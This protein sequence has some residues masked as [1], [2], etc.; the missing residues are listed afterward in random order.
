MRDFF[1]RPGRRELV[2]RLLKIRVNGFAGSLSAM[3]A[4]A[5]LLA[6]HFGLRSGSLLHSWFPAFSRAHNELGPGWMRML[7]HELITAAPVNGLARIDLGRGDEDWKCR[8]MT[9]SVS[10]CEGEVSAHVLRRRTQQ[11][12]TPPSIGLAP[13]RSGRGFARPNAGSSGLAPTS[14]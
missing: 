4:G 13:R 10:V 3:Y 2:H 1:A 7:L 11:A 12:R 9:G 6:A 8:A 14:F 5:T